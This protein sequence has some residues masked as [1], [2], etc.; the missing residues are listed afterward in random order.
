MHTVYGTMVY[1]IWRS[2]I[3]STFEIIVVYKN[4]LLCCIWR[5]KFQLGLKWT[6]YISLNF[7]G[8][9]FYSLW[10]VISTKILIHITNC[11]IFFQHIRCL[12]YLW[13]KAKIW[14][15]GEN[16]CEIKLRNLSKRSWRPRI[17]LHLPISKNY[18]A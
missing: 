13:M 14:N 4:I 1:F 5:K 16:I 11:N 12:H 15:C 9:P 6:D 3:L 18:N 8:K 17:L 10:N 7:T 2:E